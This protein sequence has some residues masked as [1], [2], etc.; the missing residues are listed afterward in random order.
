[1]E[2]EEFRNRL[3]EEIKAQ[4]T[5]RTADDANALIEVFSKELQSAEEITDDIIYAYYDELGPRNKRIGIDGYLDDEYDNILSLF[6]VP[7]IDFQDISKLTTTDA[8]ALFSKMQAFIENI[9]FVFKYA[10]Q[11]TQAYSLAYDI[12]KEGKRFDKYQ[13]YII[14][15]RVCSKSLSIPSDLKINGVPTEFYVWDVE[16]LH[17][18]Y[19]SKQ[20]KEDICIDITA[21]NNGMGIPFLEANCTELYS[22]YLCTVPGVLLAELYNKYNGRLLEGNV[23]S[24]LQ[25]RGKVNKGIR[26]TIL[27]EPEMFFAYNNGIAATAH[28][29]KTE[30]INGQPQITKIT[31]L[32]IVNGGQTTA[33]LATSY[34]KDSG[35][36][37]KIKKIYV[38]MKLSLVTPEVGEELIPNIAHYANSQ[39][40]VS[41][42]DL[43]SNHPFHIR[44]EEYS[45]RIMTPT[46][47]GSLLKTY[48]FYERAK[49]QYKQATY[50]VSD[51][52]R[53]A[54]EK[55][56]P[57]NQM[58]TKT[59]LAKYM[60]IKREL[61]HIASAGAQKSFA[62]YANFLQKDWTTHE[63]QYNEL[64]FKELVSMAI[65]YRKTDILVRNQSW[66]N[67]YKA[68]IVAYSLA[69]I[70][71]EVNVHYRGK[72]IDYNKIWLRQD[73]SDAWYDELNEV[74]KLI[75]DFL[76]TTN[77]VVKN[78][79]EYAKRELC[80]TRAQQLDISLQE[81]FVKELISIND[82]NSNKKEAKETLSMDKEIDVLKEIYSKDLALWEKLLKWNLTA[83]VLS[84]DQKNIVG[85]VISYLKGSRNLSNKQAKLA[86]IAFNRATDEGFNA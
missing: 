56:N 82:Y 50:K 63:D 68:N 32:Q 61:P 4:N 41:D 11:S 22:A 37:E 12:V 66:Y 29:I 23:R 65:L 36:K 45:R 21:F 31:G 16:R 78:V 42:S 35:A 8:T 55:Q 13:L 70:I 10:N 27:R 3:L 59:D 28:A 46:Q 30:Y 48:W 86:I 67:S 49:G 5:T 69:K 53:K 38:P 77:D 47:S 25:S 14:T 51:R 73:L 72:V 1:M 74:T 6:I 84:D 76:T 75:N 24:F 54:F 64:Y 9:D 17:R 26:S 40:K 80:W 58:F 79:T 52:E 44:M 15:D 60:N 57:K 34:I 62:T 18:L 7:S 71:H 39:N 20:A 43:W 85:Y 83:D 19:E 81:N 2:L 33:S